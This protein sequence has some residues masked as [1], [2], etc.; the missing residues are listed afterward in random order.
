MARQKRGI[1]RRPSR[2]R[3]SHKIL[4][5]KKDVDTFFTSCTKRAKQE[6][7]CAEFRQVPWRMS[8]YILQKYNQQNRRK[9][10]ATILAYADDMRNDD[11]CTIEVEPL[12]LDESKRV[13]SGQGRLEAQVVN[14]ESGLEQ[15][16]IWLFTFGLSNDERHLVDTPRTRTAVHQMN[17]ATAPKIK[18]LREI[19]GTKAPGLIRAILSAPTFRP[20]RLSKSQDNEA[21]ELF[22][23]TLVWW[24]SIP[25][26]SALP[27]KETGIAAALCRARLA[28]PGSTGEIEEFATALSTTNFTDAPN[29][30]LVQQLYNRIKGGEVKAKKTELYEKTSFALNAHINGNDIKRLNTP[31]DEPFALGR[32]YQE[33]LDRVQSRGDSEI[34]QALKARRKA[35]RAAA[36][37]AKKRAPAK[38]KKRVTA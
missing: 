7:G 15:D 26:Y 2:S 10:D 30:R 4:A 34:A 8:D 28:Y 31:K 38:R 35:E 36:K 14:G 25:G 9:N 23:P 12:I 19:V 6:G 3:H 32:R 22:T 18:K 21:L 17:M 20:P 13:V 37:P 1:A 24:Q 11:W 33:L 5:T 29:A 16:R 27:L